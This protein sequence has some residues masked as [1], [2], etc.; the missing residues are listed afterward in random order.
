M[1]VTLQIYDEARSQVLFDLN[2]P[3]GANSGLYGGVTTGIGRDGFDIGTPELQTSDV[4]AQDIDATFSS[5]SKRATATMKGTIL[6]QATSFDRLVQAAGTLSQLLTQGCVMR[7][8]FGG[9]VYYLDVLPSTNAPVLNGNEDALYKAGVTFDMDIPLELKRQ[10]YLRAAGLDPAVNWLSNPTLLR[11]S[12]GDGLPDGWT[13]LST[14]T[15]SVVASTQSLHIVGAAAARGVRQDTATAT[16]AAGDQWTISADVQV[17]SGSVLLSIDWRTGAGAS[18]SVSSVAS[19]SATWTRITVT[20][21]APATTDHIRARIETNGAAATFDVRNIQL[22][23]ASAQ[24]VFRV[25]S[26]TVLLDPAGAGFAKMLPVW[27]PSSAPAPLVIKTK[28][29]DSNS[30]VEAMDFFLATSDAIPGN[31]YLSDFLNGPYYAQ[32]EASGHGWT[33]SGGT[34]TTLA[35]TV[36]SALSP[37]SGTTGALITHSTDPRVLQKRVTFTRSTTLDSLRG[38]HRVFARVKPAFATAYKLQLK[39]SAGSAVTETNDIF[40]VDQSG[41]GTATP[42]P[43]LADL[44][45]IEIPPNPNVALNALTMELWTGM[46]GT[47]TA[48]NLAVDGLIIVPQDNSAHVVAAEAETL[49]AVTVFGEDMQAPKNIGAESWSF[50]TIKGTKVR[51]DNVNEAAAIG[52]NTTGGWTGTGSGVRQ[53]VYY[54]QSNG[55]IGTYNAEVVD[56]TSNTIVYQQSVTLP[57]GSTFGPWVTFTEAAA[58]PYQPRVTITSYASGSLDVLQ[59]DMVPILSIVQNQQ[60]RTDPGSTGL[61]R[62]AAERLDSSDN[63]VGALG[64]DRVPFWIPPGLS[65]VWL[66]SYDVNQNGSELPHINSRTLTVTPTIYPRYWG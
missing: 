8:S 38:I 48:K 65:L 1:T 17:T 23:K 10:P 60:I 54:V 40:V 41:I 20:A 45:T 46:Y 13:L 37:G 62:Y 31:K 66:E 59:I 61:D 5:F 32:A 63:Y 44:G 6:I 11:D 50:G 30:N 52:S 34:D 27:N 25:K 56:L 49:A 12:D 21:T 4:Q 57:G 53:I 28:F 26:E 19:S 58:H 51:L 22:E 64:A 7:Y 29:P 36:D 47:G 15:V 24:S 55:F 42:F 9:T 18:I 43:E 16:A 33:V 14:P 2:D 35:G 3:T 39:W